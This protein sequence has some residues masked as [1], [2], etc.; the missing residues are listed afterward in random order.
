MT[1][2]AV[3]AII[4][5]ADTG[6]ANAALAKTDA[7]L[8]ATAASADKS[9]A[10]TEASW[11]KAG[12]GMSSVGSTMTKYITLPAVAA[13]AAAIKMSL[14][15]NK[16]MTLVQTQAGASAKE[17]DKMSKSILAF[18]ASGKT[19]FT[20]NELAQGLY[21][22]E[23]AGIR[24]AK[25]LDTL[26][27][28]SKLAIV[29]QTDLASTTKALVAAQKSGIQGTG[30]LNHEIATLNATVGSGQMHMQDLLSAMGT[31]FLGSAKTLGLSL[32][33]VGGALAELTKQGVPAASAATR[34]KMTL[35]SMATIATRAA[36]KTALAGIG[37]DA[38]Q[39]SNTL[40]QGGLLAALQQLQS[41]MKGLSD[42][43]KTNILATAFGGSR[44]GGTI[45]Q[46]LGNL[47]DLSGTLDNI[48][49]HSTNIDFQ[50]SF[51][52]ALG[53]NAALVGL[54]G[55]G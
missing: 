26:K 29:G 1:P 35:T 52:K 3:L 46:L 11:A 36:S 53:T 5:N 32:T 13:G 17:V 21:A 7:A 39:L 18:A 8:K 33:D 15:F 22:I 9:A 23:S 30:D 31:G 28:S 55:V 12:K 10:A 34:L 4:V 48:K 24:G 16:S 37:I 19:I 40:R 2:A 42:A 51:T 44:S 25:A 54:R 50:K 27:A 49:K 6:Q 14:D 41:H 47:K 43:A 20:P 45:M 38:N